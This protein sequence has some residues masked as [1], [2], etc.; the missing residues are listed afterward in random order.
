MRYRYLVAEMNEMKQIYTA[1]LLLFSEQM[2]GP[3]V[4]AGTFARGIYFLYFCHWWLV[5]VVARCVCVSFIAVAT[6][7]ACLFGLAG[8]VGNSSLCR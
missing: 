7:V 1:F 6:T 8:G 2:F 5:I 3:S 4:D